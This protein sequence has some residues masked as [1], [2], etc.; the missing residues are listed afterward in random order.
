MLRQVL[1]CN[2]IGH[3]PVTCQSHASHMA[4]FFQFRFCDQQTIEGNRIQGTGAYL[5]Q[6]KQQASLW[7]RDLVW[8][9]ELVGV[10]H[11]FEKVSVL[12]IMSNN[13]YPK[14]LKWTL[15]ADQLKFNGRLAQ[16]HLA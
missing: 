6:P 15:N 14:K 12:A 5:G 2:E 7:A 13:I 8:S 10:G 3:M 1:L 9:C 11:R 16:I 4:S